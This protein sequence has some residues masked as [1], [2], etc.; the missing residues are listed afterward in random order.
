[1]AVCC[2][3]SLHADTQRSARPLRFWALRGYRDVSC[4]DGPGPCGELRL[5]AG[6]AARMR[7]GDP[8]T[9]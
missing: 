9:R 2:S 6:D 4:E 8:L 1:M 3:L 5:C 7:T